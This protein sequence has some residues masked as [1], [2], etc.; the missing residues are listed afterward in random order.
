[1]A[2]LFDFNFI[3]VIYFNVLFYCILNI[4]LKFE[5]DIFRYANSQSIPK[6]AQLAQ[7]ADVAIVFASVEAGEGKDRTN[8]SLSGNQD[9]L[10][11]AVAK[12]QKNTVVV[13]HV[14]GAVLMDWLDLVSSVLCA[15]YPGQE[16]GILFS[17]YFFLLLFCSPSHRRSFVCVILVIHPLSNSLF[18]VYFPYLF[19]LFLF[20][21]FF[22]WLLEN[23]RH[24]H[25]S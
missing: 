3:Y 1:M 12:V 10:I 6:A 4:M 23:N 2:M 19:F 7:T 8:L 11:A 24:R 22:V 13:L 15:F 21:C 14:P 16:D 5:I 18:S 9:E 17:S 20:F 25:S